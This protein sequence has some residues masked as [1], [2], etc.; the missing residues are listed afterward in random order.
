M[1]PDTIELSHT[2]STDRSA[3]RHRTTLVAAL[4]VILLAIGLRTTHYTGNPSLWF[5]ELAIARNVAD[6]SLVELIFEPLDH[7]QVAPVGFLVAVKIST[8]LLGSSEFAFRFVPWVGALLAPVLF[9]LVA[10]RF[11]GGVSLIAGLLLFAISPA[12]T[13][14]GGNC[15]QYS[16]DVTIA[17]LLVWLAMRFRDRPADMRRA[18]TAGLIGGLLLLC[19]QPAV[20]TAFLLGLILLVEWWRR[21][22]ERP[23]STLATIGGGWAL[24]AFAAAMLMLRLVDEQTMVHMKSFWSEGFPP[25]P[26]AA[27]DSLLWYPLQTIETFGV[28][29]FHI[30]AKSSPLAQIV[31]VLSVIA[32]GGIIHLARG[33]RW[34]AA[35]LA[36]PLIGALLAATVHL[37]PFRDR[38]G[39][40]AS[41]P[42]LIMAMSGFEALHCWM[43][44]KVRWIAPATAIFLAGVPAAAVLTVGRPPYRGHQEMRPLL[45]D[46]AER[47]K[48]GDAIYVFHG[49]RHAMHFYGSTIGIKE[50]EWTEGGVH[51]GDTRAY[52]HEVDAFRGEPRF[53]FVY[54]QTERFEAPKAIVAYLDSIGE[55]LEMI[56]DPYGRGGQSEV[57]AYLYDLSD[58][59]RLERANAATFTLPELTTR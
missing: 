7:R 43:P 25:P 34:T 3:G 45:A 55:Q 41:W 13:W 11:V 20:V 54:T 58:P 38:V 23:F 6:R 32:V 17:L 30:G 19:S 9:W 35:L 47:R 22:S 10:R 29:L 39:M 8:T 49:A 56:P 50:D 46:F 21:R 2:T 37:L 16:G 1:V 18:L 44:K 48:A 57:A 12:Q 52:L 31:I 4:V 24:G 15:K 53:W 36:A 27:L 14:F 26:S 59:G 28:F 5:D 33:D 42:I 40:H 51:Y